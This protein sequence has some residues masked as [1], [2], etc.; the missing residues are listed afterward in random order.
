MRSCGRRSDY[1]T[2]S[3]TFRKLKLNSN[4]NGNS[5]PKLSPAALYSEIES[6]APKGL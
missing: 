3:R 4:S 6:C 1:P 5:K 2:E